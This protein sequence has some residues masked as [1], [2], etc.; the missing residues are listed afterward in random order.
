MNKKIARHITDPPSVRKI[1]KD[2]NALSHRV[3]HY[4]DKSISRIDFLREITK[5][6]LDFSECN[7]VELRIKKEDMCFRCEA[8]Q[9]SKRPFSIEVT[10]AGQKDENALYTCAQDWNDC[11]KLFRFIVEKRFDP[12]LPFFT[13]HGSFFT[14]N[15]KFSLPRVLDIDTKVEEQVQYNF[16][17][18]SSLLIIPIIALNETIGLVQLKSEKEEYFDGDNVELYEFIV[19][20]LGLV[21]INQLAHTALRERVKELTCLYSVAQLTERTNITLDEI[22]QGIAE[23]LPPAWQH[24]QIT[25]GCITLDGQ[26]YRTANYKNGVHKQSSEIVINDEWRGAIEV[27]YLEKK[28]ELDEGPFLKEER[29]LIDTLARQII[30]LIQRRKA[31]EDKLRLQD[32]LR[33]ADRLATIGQLAAGVAHEL[34]E[35]LA[36]ILGFAQLAKKC[37]D[38]PQSA[39]GDIDKIETAS[40]HARE[41]IKKLMYFA[42]QMPPQKIQVNLNKVVEEGLYFLESRCVKDG[43]ELLRTLSSEIPNITADPA[44]LNQI[45]VNLVVNALH[46]MPEGGI[47]KVCTLVTKKDVSLIVEDTGIGMSEEILEQI[48]LPFF[49]TKDVGQGTG[50]GLPVVHGIVTSHGGRIKVQSEVGKGT[51]IEIQLPPANAPRN[52]E[53][54]ENVGT[55]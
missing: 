22:L 52:V 25:A 16:G 33:H 28:S 35:P 43:I 30:L 10:R 54:D 12:S 47:L 39:I 42:R 21:V 48:F 20:T 4:T 45:L 55:I 34:N 17:N 15:S 44:Q 29:S 37:H 27:V 23:L 26:S 6:L 19:Q 50:L 2:F 13:K 14:G 31:D 3:L 7:V 38:L 32:Q 51:R 11:E 24:P 1:P 8:M 18:Y 49:T 36:N 5:T 40:L 53:K 41:M 9:R 46:A